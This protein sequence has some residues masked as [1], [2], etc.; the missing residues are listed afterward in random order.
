MSIWWLLRPISAA[1]SPLS[2]LFS[3]WY[4][5]YVHLLVRAA[6]ASRRGHVRCCRHHAEAYSTSSHAAALVFVP[7]L[8][9]L[10]LLLLVLSLL[11]SLMLQGALYVCSTP[12][13]FSTVDQ[14]IRIMYMHIYAHTRH[15]YILCT[16]YRCCVDFYVCLCCGGPQT[17]SW[18]ALTISSLRYFAVMPDITWYN[19]TASLLRLEL[20]ITSSILHCK[21]IIVYASVVLNFID[22]LLCFWIACHQ[23]SCFASFSVNHMDL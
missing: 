20:P 6:T 10:L 11:M 1:V 13:F 7:W 15:F 23:Y 4:W 14:Q 12:A 21:L 17:V 22:Y 19:I 5:S 16:D 3:P 2:S 9:V 8:L 18:T